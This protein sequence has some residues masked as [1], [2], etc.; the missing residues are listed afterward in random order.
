MNNLLKTYTIVEAA[1]AYDLPVH[2]LRRWINDGSIPACRS[3]RRF[4]VTAQN[5]EAFLLK[6][7]TQ[8]APESKKFGLIRRL[9]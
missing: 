1:Q 2:A 9:G 4:L 3:G 8:P 6:G 7:N 5:I